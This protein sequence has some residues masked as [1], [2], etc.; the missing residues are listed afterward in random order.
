MESFLTPLGILNTAFKEIALG[1]YSSAELV[2]KEVATVSGTFKAWDMATVLGSTY[3]RVLGPTSGYEGPIVSPSEEILRSFD[4][5]QQKRH[6]EARASI[7]DL[8]TYLEVALNEVDEVDY[9]LPAS[10]EAAKGIFRST[11]EFLEAELAVLQAES[12]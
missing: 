7:Y 3:M 4:L 5:T 1:K 10:K 6:D 2:V 11:R 9:V 8:I 12:R